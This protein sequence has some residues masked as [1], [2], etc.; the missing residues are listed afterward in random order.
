MRTNVRVSLCERVL[1]I[2]SPASRCTVL[3]VNN[4]AYNTN[5]CGKLSGIIVRLNL[6]LECVVESVGHEILQFSSKFQAPTVIL[7]HFKYDELTRALCRLL[8]KFD[9]VEK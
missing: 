8:P 2:I 7:E 1:L 6:R 5:H 9:G 3:A 4:V